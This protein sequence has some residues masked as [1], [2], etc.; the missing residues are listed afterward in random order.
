MK[1]LYVVKTNEGAGW[2]YRQARWIIENTQ[3]VEFVIAMPSDTGGF[4]DQYKELGCKV[5][6]YDM[7]LPVSRP[8]SFFRK[9]K[10]ILQIVENENPDMI[11]SHFVTTTFM[12]RLAL[13]KHSPKRIFQVP[14]PL[15]LENPFFKWFDKASIGEKD[16]LVGTCTWTSDTYKQM[17]V[18]TDRVFMCYYGGG[19]GK[20]HSFTTNKLREEYHIP[21]ETPLVGMVSFFYAPKY[22]LGQFVGLKGHEDY[23]KAMKIVREKI[24]AAKGVV[25]GSAWGKKAQKYEQRVRKYAE[26]VCPGG[27]IFTGFRNDVAEIYHEFNV[28]VHP[29]HSENLGGAG[30]SLSHGA[31]TV[32][33]N[34]GGFPDL[35]INGVTGWTVDK[36]SPKQL[37]DR[38][39]W[40]LEHQEEALQMMRVG[41]E[42]VI[43]LTALPVTAAKMLE[44]YRH[45]A[46]L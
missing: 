4:A 42:R 12:L 2:A 27:I 28:A 18:P 17:G 10:E 19:D 9:R 30:E 8:W 43:E 38:I 6:A 7:S 41:A 1:I 23:I 3:D 46:Q 25:V 22:Y 32:S 33:T 36:K 31:P 13:G 44:I 39:I 40:V 45:I 5:I 24:P 20:I 35:V 37:A 26:K 11:H 21:N 34:V 29:S 15:H 16:Y 14:G